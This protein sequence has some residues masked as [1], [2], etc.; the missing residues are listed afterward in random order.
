MKNIWLITVLLILF[1]ILTFAG[2]SSPETTSKNVGFFNGVNVVSKVD[3]VLA[4]IPSGEVRIT[5]YKNILKHVDISVKDSVL[6]IGYSSETPYSNAD[7]S[8]MVSVKDVKYLFADG[9]AR[10]IADKNVKAE[11]IYITLRLGSSFEGELNVDNVN[12]TL[13]AGSSFVSGINSKNL[14]V[15]SSKNSTLTVDSCRVDNIDLSLYSGG[16]NKLLNIKASTIKVSAE[17]GVNLY[18]QGEV[19][20]LIVNA[21][22]YCNVNCEKLYADNAIVTITENSVAKIRAMNTL[23]VKASD[24]SSVL[25]YGDVASPSILSTDGSMVEKQ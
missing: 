6:Y 23:S 10:L 17:T 16:E 21:L 7:L 13:L 24:K 15:N 25:Y 19:K 5:T 12:L 18:M 2:L 11:D 8:V 1:P 22:E 9:G 4:N 3:V 20:S 14:T